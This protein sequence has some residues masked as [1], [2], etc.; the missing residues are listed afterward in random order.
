MPP[1]SINVKIGQNT[2]TINFPNNGQLIDIESR[3]MA[4]SNGTHRDMMLSMS[5]STQKAFVIGEAIT[6]FTVLIPSLAK[7]LNVPSLLDLD[8]VQTKGI[9]KE[10]MRKYY[11][12]FKQWMDVLNEDLDDE[13]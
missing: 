3:K 10:Y 1:R 9:V 6:T 12:W 7:D 13:E 8:P 4:L 11:P 5:E 2:Y